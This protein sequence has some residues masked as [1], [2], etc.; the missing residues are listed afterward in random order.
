M[1]GAAA[2]LGGIFP[3]RHPLIACV[4]LMALPGAPLYGGSMSAI[5]D[6][7]MREAEIYKRHRVDGLIVENFHDRPFYPGR[8]PSETVAAMSVIAAELARVGLPFGVNVLRNDAESALGIACASGAHFI[9]VNVHMNAVVADQGILQGMS[10]LTLRLRSQLGAGTLIFADVGVKHASPLGARN[11]ALEADN[12]AKRGMAD[13]VI[14]SGDLTGREVDLRD[15]ESVRGAT[16]AP[17]LIGSGMTPSNLPALAAKCDGFIV[18]SYFKR[19]GL[20]DN[21]IDESRLGTFRE[22]LEALR[23]LR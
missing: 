10:H 2:R 15:L 4:H 14:V 5:L 19:D 22:K 16:S 8:V 21:E 13:A 3:A 20:A 7:A 6:R 11:I 23:A 18:G 12:V 9:R 1:S 17:L